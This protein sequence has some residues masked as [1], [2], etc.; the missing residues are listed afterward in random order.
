MKRAVER[1]IL[2]P[3]SRQSMLRSAAK[4][5][6]HVSAPPGLQCSQ[7]EDKMRPSRTEAQARIEG[8]SQRG[9]LKWPVTRE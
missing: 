4:A 5:G 1:N 3:R 9:E 8:Q 2:A 6:R 7:K